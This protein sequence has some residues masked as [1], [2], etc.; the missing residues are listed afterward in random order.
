ME[1]SKSLQADIRNI[2]NELKT[3]IQS[4][5]ASINFSIFWVTLSA[6][7]LKVTSTGALANNP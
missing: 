1:V 2:Q 5:Q 3:A 4:H 7:F 6:L